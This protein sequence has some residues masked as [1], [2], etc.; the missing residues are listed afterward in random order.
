MT[1]GGEEIQKNLGGEGDFKK[2]LNLNLLLLN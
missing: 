2:N 1:K